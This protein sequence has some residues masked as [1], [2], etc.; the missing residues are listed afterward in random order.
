MQTSPM[1]R[2]LRALAL[3]ALVAGAAAPAADPPALRQDR[4]TALALAQTVDTRP[5]INQLFTLTVS[6]STPEALDLLQLTRN[7]NDWPAPARDLAL[8]RYAEQLRELPASAVA[9]ELLEWLEAIE[10]LTWVAHEDHAGGAVPLFNVRATVAGVQNS[11]RRQEAMLE[12]LAL[13]GSSPRALADAWLLEPHTASRAGYLQALEQAGSA[14]LRQLSR[15]TARRAASQEE[16]APLA[17]HAALLSGRLD[18]LATVLALAP[19]AETARLLRAA[20]QQL[21]PADCARLMARLV[22]T[23]SPTTASL[24]IAELYP[25]APAQMSG[26]LLKLLGDP[27]L[28]GSAALALAQ[29]PDADLQQRLQKL[30]KS[31]D[32]LTAARARLALAPQGATQEPGQ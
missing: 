17:G 19:N 15:H 27:Q 14:E 8:Q 18:N 7:R 11:W 13:L 2:V 32:P 12:G 4:D 30:S 29:H 26:Q 16:L 3:A 24:A 6:G 21:E 9:T 25:R 20:A 23:A 22:T 1:S 5:A 10:P 31:A 28:G